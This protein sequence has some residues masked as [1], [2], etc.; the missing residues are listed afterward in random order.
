NPYGKL[1]WCK[2]GQDSKKNTVGNWFELL[3]SWFDTSNGV[4]GGFNH[5]Q[6]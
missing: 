4:D 1:S 2:D 3:D 5:Y 6:W